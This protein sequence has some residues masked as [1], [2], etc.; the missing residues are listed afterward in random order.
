MVSLRFYTRMLNERRLQRHI[1]HR[2]KCQ[3]VEN[4]REKEALS[5]FH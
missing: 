3:Q 1:Q 4:E 2:G 5:N